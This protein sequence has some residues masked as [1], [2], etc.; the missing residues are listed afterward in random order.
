MYFLQFTINIL[1]DYQEFLIIVKY[2]F[3][4]TNL[5]SSNRP[6]VYWTNFSYICEICLQNVSNKQINVQ[7]MGECRIVIYSVIVKCKLLLWYNPLYTGPYSDADLHEKGCSP[8]YY[9]M[10]W[11][12]MFIDKWNLLFYSHRLLYHIY[13]NSPES[14]QTYAINKRKSYFCT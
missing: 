2:F 6:I 11:T 9:K 13:N 8:P 10:H 14:I 3:R 4:S 1:W 12:N 7:I 5:T